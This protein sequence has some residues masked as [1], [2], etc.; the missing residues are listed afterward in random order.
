MP[1][2]YTGLPLPPLGAGMQDSPFLDT[3]LGS[4]TVLLEAARIG[5]PA[6]GSEINPAAVAMARTYQF[7]NVPLVE[8]RLYL[9][10]TSRLLEMALLQPTSPLEDAENLKSSLVDI[11]F[12]TDGFVRILTE[13]LIVIVDFYKPSITVDRIFRTWENIAAT[14]L[15]LPYSEEPITAFNSD[16][17]HLPLQ[18]SSVNFVLTSPPYIN[19]FNYHQRFRASMEALNWNLLQV[20]QSEF[21]ANRKHRSN[22][23]L[24]VVQFCLDLS[25][26]FFELG[27]VCRPDARLIFVVGR[28]STVS[29]TKFLNGEIVSELAGR[30]LGFGLTL[31]Q[32]RA[33]RNRYG[34]WI[35]EDILHFSPPSKLTTPSFTEARIVAQQALEDAYRTAPAKA[36]AGLLS[37]LA[38]IEEVAP[39]PMY[40]AG[41]AILS[42]SRGRYG[43]G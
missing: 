32:E 27:R 36:L 4:G 38:N 2:H 5:L 11:A 24:T 18:D 20:A 6:F 23:F 17:R 39:S 19:V 35:Y 28:E 3:L 34:N 21:G 12:S 30:V 7:A 16:V 10:H 43:N 40:D 14:V 41:V 8:R 31:R 26:A 25:S 29:G 22:R 37:A 42:D 13:L 1:P 15:T 9:E 33:F